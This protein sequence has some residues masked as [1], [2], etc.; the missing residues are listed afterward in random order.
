MHRD[1]GVK[2]QSF[3]RCPQLRM[4]D[5][6]SFRRI[7]N[8]N[9]DSKQLSASVRGIILSFV[10]VLVKCAHSADKV[11]RLRLL[12]APKTGALLWR[13]VSEFQSANRLPSVA[14]T[15]VRVRPGNYVRWPQCIRSCRFCSFSSG[16]IGCQWTNFAALIVLLCASKIKTPT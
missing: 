6:H 16:T 7:V 9:N 13:R 15:V 1:R 5:E 3:S 12:L 8:E 4:R 2:C 14:V 11:A 10:F